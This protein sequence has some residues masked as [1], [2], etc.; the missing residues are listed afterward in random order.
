MKKVLALAIATA[1]STPVFADHTT[2]QW[3]G[4]WP[5]SETCRHMEIY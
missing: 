3:Y 1:V 2:H 4:L 5:T